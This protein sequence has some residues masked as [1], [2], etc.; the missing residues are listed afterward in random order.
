LLDLWFGKL[1]IVPRTECA[2]LDTES[3]DEVILWFGRLTTPSKTE[4][5][6]DQAQKTA[7]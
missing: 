2:S 4:G 5:S 1:T 7:R 3:R 6:K